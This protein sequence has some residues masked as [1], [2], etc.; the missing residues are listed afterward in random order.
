MS[1]REAKGWARRLNST[2][3]WSLTKWGWWSPVGTRSDYP[4][5]ITWRYRRLLTLSHSCSWQI[6]HVC[7]QCG[8]GPWTHCT[9]VVCLLPVRMVFSKTVASE[10]YT[11]RRVSMRSSGYCSRATIPREAW[12][13]HSRFPK[14]EVY[15]VPKRADEHPR[16]QPAAEL[17]RAPGC[18]VGTVQPSAPGPGMYNMEDRNRRGSFP[19]PL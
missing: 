17:P 1:E 11:N 8:V 3:S 4:A 19:P 10:K 7:H 16:A 5:R 9:Q 2:H 13:K 6:F 18:M 15:S 12:A 14:A